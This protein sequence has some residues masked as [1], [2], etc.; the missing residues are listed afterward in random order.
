[1]MS[2]ETTI[3]CPVL[4]DGEPCGGE[5]LIEWTEN[6]E[7]RKT[8]FRSCTYCDQSESIATSICEDFEGD[9]HPEHKFEDDWEEIVTTELVAFKSW[10]WHGITKSRATEILDDMAVAAAERRADGE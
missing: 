5:I 9:E 2:A 4:V 6:I 7:H 3:Q 8:G 1:M 10:C